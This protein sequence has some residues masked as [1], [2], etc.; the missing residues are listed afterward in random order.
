MD[1]GKIAC[2]LV[3]DLLLTVDNIEEQYGKWRS[4]SNDIKEMI[5][6]AWQNLVF[7][8]LENIEIAS[9]K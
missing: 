4:L 7:N 1:K 6:R 5:K 2:E 3:D 9:N 8:Y